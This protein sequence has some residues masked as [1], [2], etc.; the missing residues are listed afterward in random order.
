M[1]NKFIFLVL[2]VLFLGTISV[3]AGNVFVSE[4]GI[5]AE[6]TSSLGSEGKSQNVSYRNEAGELGVLMFENGI[7]VGIGNEGSSG[8]DTSGW[9]NVNW[10]KRKSVTISET[11]GVDLVN[12]QL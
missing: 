1:N 11:S 8:G 3:L 7:F 10:G 6:Y 12:Y 4:S 5:R 9:W 2:S